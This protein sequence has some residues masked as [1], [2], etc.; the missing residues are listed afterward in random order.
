MRPKATPRTSMPSLK[1]KSLSGFSDLWDYLPWGRS[2]SPKGNRDAEEGGGAGSSINK[3]SLQ[4]QQ[5]AST[6]DPATCEAKES[7]PPGLLEDGDNSKPNSS[8]LPWS[9]CTLMLNKCPVQCL[10]CTKP[11]Y[12]LSL[13]HTISSNFY[14]AYV[15]LFYITF[16]YKH[17]RCLSLTSMHISTLLPNMCFQRQETIP[18]VA[19]CFWITDNDN[20]NREALP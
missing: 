9:I 15:R 16:L 3:D 19:T 17:I 18:Y 5:T 20:T 12:S 4:R 10:S 6:S 14:R 11:A 2:K 7:P 8:G 13:N 1:K